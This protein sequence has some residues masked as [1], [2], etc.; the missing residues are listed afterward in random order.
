[1]HFQQEASIWR[2]QGRSVL[3]HRSLFSKARLEVPSNHSLIPK[4]E[5]L[6]LVQRNRKMGEEA[7]SVL[8]G[9]S[10]T[11]RMHRTTLSIH[12]MKMEMFPFQLYHS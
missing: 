6:F 11:G 9:C 10:L 1:M 5:S 3:S 7:L 12:I 8:L 2:R 4:V